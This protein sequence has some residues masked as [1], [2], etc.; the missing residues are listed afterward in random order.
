MTL[1]KIFA[2]VLIG[3][4]SGRQLRRLS[5]PDPDLWLTKSDTEAGASLDNA[6]LDNLW[7][8]DAFSDE[9]LDQLLDDGNGENGGNRDSMA[10]GEED[11][12]AEDVRDAEVGIL[13]FS[14]IYDW[15]YSRTRGSSR[16]R[17]SSQRPGRIVSIHYD[18]TTLTSTFGQC[19]CKLKEGAPGYEADCSESYMG[20]SRCTSSSSSPHEGSN[21]EE[22]YNEL[23]N[24]RMNGPS[25]GHGRKLSP[26]QMAPRYSTVYT[27]SCMGNPR[28]CWKLERDADGDCSP[29]G[30]KQLLTSTRRPTLDQ[31]KAAALADPHCGTAD[32]TDFDTKN[33]NILFQNSC[34]LQRAT[35]TLLGN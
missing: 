9:E 23:Y 19:H 31:C 35:K 22:L 32:G 18:H 28:Y 25:W 17:R 21:D 16:R 3:S 11:A 1:S 5:D 12:D 27:G 14:P 7:R 30:V 24:A 13:L 6:Y 15:A 29:H 4:S 8:S 10:S 20:Q 34:W 2:L 33:C 26:C